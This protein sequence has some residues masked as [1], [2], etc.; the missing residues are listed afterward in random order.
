MGVE[1]GLFDRRRIAP[2][3]DGDAPSDD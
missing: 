1:A 2:S 3:L